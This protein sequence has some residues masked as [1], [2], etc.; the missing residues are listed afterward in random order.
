MV[1][2]AFAVFIHGAHAQVEWMSQTSGGEHLWTI[3]MADELVGVAAGYEFRRT[4]DGGATWTLLP[5]PA[6][7]FVRDI[8][9]VTPQKGWLAASKIMRT[10]DGGATWADMG[11]TSSGAKSVHMLTEQMGWFGGQ[12]SNYA[13]TVKRTVNG[14]QS[15]QLLNTLDSTN[16]T[17]IQFVDAMNGW[18]TDYYGRVLRTADGGTTWTEQ[19]NDPWITF[20]VIHMR[21]A[22]NGWCAGGTDECPSYGRLFRTSNGGD[23]WVPVPLYPSWAQIN[24]IATHGDQ[25]IWLACGSYCGSM[26]G[27]VYRSSN[28]GASWFADAVPN[29]IPRSSI[30]VIDG[31]VG[32]SSGH[33]G[34]VV[35]FSRSTVGIMEW[36]SEEITAWWD[37]DAQ[38]LHLT[39]GEPDGPVFLEVFNAAGAVLMS[40][41]S[42]QQGVVQLPATAS[43]MLLLRIVQGDRTR[44]LR[45]FR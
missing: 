22:Q 6:V 34:D 38:A 1:C 7:G 20:N 4:T 29:N 14:G 26:L 44:T 23:T 15:W 5:D 35:H 12:A 40:R 24:G 37:T 21:D 31:A 32:W 17:D 30:H 19:M 13:G 16:I 11:T 10:L 36:S 27:A 42:V 43:G 2:L 28:G 25:E 18:I 9:F 33:D 3:A 45:V 8:Q 41:T 39:T